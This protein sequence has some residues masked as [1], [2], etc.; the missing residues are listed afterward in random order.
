MK[1]FTIAIMLLCGSWLISKA[2]YESVT[3]KM[4]DGQN[5]TIELSDNL[6]VTFNNESMLVTGGS[7]DVTLSKSDIQSFT[8]NDVS[9]LTAPGQ[10]GAGV[11]FGGDALH[12][13]GIGDNSAV[14]VY[15]AAGALV[16]THI[17][18]GNF[19]LSLSSLSPGVYI[20]TVNGLS[21]KILVK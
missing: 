12:F 5:V 9:A 4:N 13:T 14:K 3:V 7:N 21:Y 20:V 18:S 10:D 2:G 16:S 6:N 15:N 11:A 1:K 19:S 8:F 17:A